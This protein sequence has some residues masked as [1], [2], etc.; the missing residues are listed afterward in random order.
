MQ[1]TASEM[2]GPGTVALKNSLKHLCLHFGENVSRLNV[3]D[4]K[5]HL[6]NLLSL[7]PPVDLSANVFTSVAQPNPHP[8]SCKY[9]VF[10]KFLMV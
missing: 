3:N 1:N 7:S 8:K 9:F 10:I 5:L 6:I 2:K 4:F